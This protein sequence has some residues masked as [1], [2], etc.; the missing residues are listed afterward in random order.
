MFRVVL[1]LRPPGLTKGMFREATQQLATQLA[2]D[3]PGTT[4]MGLIFYAGRRGIGM[5]ATRDIYI[6][7][8]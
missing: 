3:Y 8:D 5:V 2:K 1:R 6:S 7:F 4:I